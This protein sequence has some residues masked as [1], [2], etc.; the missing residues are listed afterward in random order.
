MGLTTKISIPTARW[1]ETE[2]GVVNCTGSASFKSLS[3]IMPAEWSL[4]IQQH[5]LAI[6]LLTV[7]W[8][9]AVFTFKFLQH[10]SKG[11]FFEDPP[12]NAL[13]FNETGAS[14]RSLKSWRTRWGGASNCL[15]VMITRD[16][17]FIRPFFPF[18]ILGPDF[19]LVHNVPL[20]CIESVTPNNG[21]FQKTLR[22]RFRL[23]D[24]SSREL[25]IV[26]RKFGELESALKAA[27]PK[28]S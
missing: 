11:H 24:G 20:G 18:L 25:D 6:W 12:A 27:T 14:G 3:K 5:F 10:R 15:K 7:A 4:F 22:I 26:S 2:V 17:L 28:A 23:S 9:I 16:S 21:A 1:R 19:D 13:I 8:I